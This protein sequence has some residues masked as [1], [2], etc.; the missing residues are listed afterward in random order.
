MWSLKLSINYHIKNEFF[1]DFLGDGY[2]LR[3]GNAGAPTVYG[4]FDN[5]ASIVAFLRTQMRNLN[6]FIFTA[7][8]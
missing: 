2:Y 5:L 7:L 6:N 3:A 8:I 4:M 1:N